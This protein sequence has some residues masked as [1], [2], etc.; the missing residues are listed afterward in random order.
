MR[1][2]LAML[3]SAAL[4]LLTPA[5]IR[6]DGCYIDP[7]TGI[8]TCP[9]PPR[10]CETIAVLDYVIGDC[11][12]WHFENSCTHEITGYWAACN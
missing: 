10:H 2:V 11:S 3:V 1:K 12:Y 5:S 6:A 4:L 9:Q 8:E 7:D